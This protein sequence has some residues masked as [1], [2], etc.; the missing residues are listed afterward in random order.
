MW[1]VGESPTLGWWRGMNPLFADR[2]RTVFV[3][4]G[5]QALLE[6]SGSGAGFLFL[7]ASSYRRAGG[8]VES[9]T[10]EGVRV[11]FFSSQFPCFSFQPSM[12]P[13]RT[14]AQ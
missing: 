14:L 1:M 11:L 8:I 10:A 9:C 7:E 6:S 5:N 3:P 2:K 4:D 13:S 12:V